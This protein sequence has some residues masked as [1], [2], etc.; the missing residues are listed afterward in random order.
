M[1]AS[2]LASVTCLPLPPHLRLK[3]RV[4]GGVAH[5]FSR[6]GLLLCA[7]LRSPPCRRALRAPHR[8]LR[9]ALLL[10]VLL[11][12]VLLLLVRRKAALRV[13]GRPP[14]E[15][16]GHLL[17]GRQPGSLRVTPWGTSEPPGHWSLSCIWNS[18]CMHPASSQVCK[19]D[20]K[21]QRGREGGEGT[22]HRAS[23]TCLTP[24][25]VGR[26]EGRQAGSA[27]SQPWLAA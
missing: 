16:R 27:P 13:L 18:G 6:R 15:G 19:S 22:S 21:M 2:P 26:E 20:S 1:G 9:P 3:Q 8:L 7:L 5:P 12:L 10:L 11:L 17:D 14:R 4:A 23:H 24:R 25:H